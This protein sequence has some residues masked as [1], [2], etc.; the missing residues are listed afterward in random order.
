MDAK[1]DRKKNCLIVRNL[2]MDD[3]IS[4]SAELI[5]ALAI[6][7]DNFA[8]DNECDS[9]KF[10]KTTPRGLGALMIKLNK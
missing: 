8:I 2:C 3:H 10:E 5:S 9:I 1:A 7:L 6:G 4:L